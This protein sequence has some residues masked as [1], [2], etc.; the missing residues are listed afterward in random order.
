MCAEPFCVCGKG[1]SPVVVE[2]VVAKRDRKVYPVLPGFSEARKWLLRVLG[3]ELRKNKSWRVT[4]INEF[5]GTKPIANFKDKAN[6]D[7]HFQPQKQLRLL[8]VA[9]Y[10]DLKDKAMLAE[11]DGLPADRVYRILSE[12]M[13]QDSEAI[14]KLKDEFLGGYEYFR[15]HAPSSGDPRDLV[16]GFLR[17]DESA[18]GTITFEHRSHDWADEG[19]EH[20]GWVF[21]S[22]GKIFMLA[23]RPG[24]LR[25]AIADAPPGYDPNELGMKALV[26]S[27][28]TG[29]KADWKDP[30]AAKA[31]VFKS[32]CKELAEFNQIPEIDQSK[33]FNSLFL[34]GNDKKSGQDAFAQIPYLSL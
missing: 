32:N 6:E 20:T 19:P 9:E 29:S 14:Q 17:L 31:L 5:L 28:R 13:G 23:T 34:K 16:K 2:A 4:I 1:S 11:S 24:V 3:T 22:R 25:L 10:I 12:L 30:F 27:V 33:R 21:L 15:Y 7:H 18:S 8:K 26:L